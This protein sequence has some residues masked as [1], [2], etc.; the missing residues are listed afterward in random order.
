MVHRTCSKCGETKPDTREHFR[1]STKK[2]SHPWCK[3]CDSKYHYARR[4]LLP[5]PAASAKFVNYKT[6]D[7]RKGLSNDLT[8]EFVLSK[9]FEPCAYCGTTEGFRGLDR[10]DNSLGHLQSNVVPC[11]ALCNYTRNDHFTIEEMQT[12]LGPAIAQIRKQRNESRTDSG[13]G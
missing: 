11:C 3:P 10:L 9:S 5:R 13:Q 4:Q 12:V 1:A 2:A 7:K 6:S 8:L